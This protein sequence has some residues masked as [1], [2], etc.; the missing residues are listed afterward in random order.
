MDCRTRNPSCCKEESGLTRKF[1]KKSLK[2]DRI[3]YLFILPFFLVFSYFYFIPAFQVILDSFTDYDLFTSRNFVGLANYQALLTDDKF[4]QSVQNTFLYTIFTLFPTLALGLLLASLANSALIKSKISRMLIFMPHVVSMVA[5]SMIW[6]FLYEPTN[7]IFNGI[8]RAF[9]LQEYNY[10]LDPNMALPC[11]IVMG[12]WKGVGY[13]MVIF[14]SGLKSIPEQYYEAAKLDGSSALHTFFRITLPLLS[15]TTSF[16]LITGLISSFNVFEQVNIMTS[17]GPLY[18]TTTIVHQIYLNGFS[19]YKLGYAS[20]MS[21]VLLVIIMIIS[22][23]NFKL[24][25]E[26]EA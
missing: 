21:V 5:V 4:M 12:I 17:G 13:N 11:L 10:L 1:R 7:G 26:K 16:L 8:L 20:A 3:A 2:Y 24:T 19:Q 25:Q 15:P 14:L 9:G 22:A 18:R 6:I 23:V